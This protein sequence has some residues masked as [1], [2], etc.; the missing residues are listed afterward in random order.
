MTAHTCAVHHWCNGTLRILQKHPVRTPIQVLVQTLQMCT[1]DS[2]KAHTQWN[3]AKGK[4]ASQPCKKRTQ[5]AQE[6]TR[7][8]NNVMTAHNTS[9]TLCKLRLVNF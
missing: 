6:H 7:A 5:A 9:N 3:C 4:T 2:L 8:R 1:T